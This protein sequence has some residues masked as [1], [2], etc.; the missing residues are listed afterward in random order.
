MELLFHLSG[1]R[2]H[3]FVHRFKCRC[4]NTVMVSNTVYPALRIGSILSLMC[5]GILHASISKCP[6]DLCLVQ[7]NQAILDHYINPNAIQRLNSI[8][9]LRCSAIL[10]PPPASNKSLSPHS[11]VGA[12]S[13]QF[14][15]NYHHR[16]FF[17][18]CEVIRLP[19][20]ERTFGVRLG[21][22]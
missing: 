10:L 15:P 3:I 14:R 20:R 11:S 19:L 4:C 7:C 17:Y 2:L 6:C 21:K 8:L 16:I 18:L 12:T 22:C 5:C 13:F 1:N 9:K